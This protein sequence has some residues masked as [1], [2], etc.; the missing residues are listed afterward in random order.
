MK[1]ATSPLQ[2]NPHTE[3]KPHS[4]GLKKN[5]ILKE[6]KQKAYLRYFHNTSATGLKY[7]ELQGRQLWMLVSPTVLHIN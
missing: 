4:K 5:P 2:K 7:N 1:Q 6:R 3:K